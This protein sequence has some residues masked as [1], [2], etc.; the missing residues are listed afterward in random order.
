MHKW[1]NR[2][3]KTKQ[4]ILKNTHTQL[5]K[6]RLG[7]HFMKTCKNAEGENTS[8]FSIVLNETSLSQVGENMVQLHNASELEGMG[9]GK[10]KNFHLHITIFSL[11]R[12]EDLPG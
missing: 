2:V 8:I 12:T 5:F 1:N 3:I 4:N 11:V 7:T 10:Q 9:R 6:S